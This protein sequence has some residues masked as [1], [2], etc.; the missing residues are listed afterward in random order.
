MIREF[1]FV[2]NPKFQLQFCDASH[3]NTYGRL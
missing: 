3:P 1:V 2:F